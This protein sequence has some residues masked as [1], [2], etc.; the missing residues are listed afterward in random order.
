VQKF[1]GRLPLSVDDFGLAHKVAEEFTSTRPTAKALNA[2]FKYGLFAAVDRFGKDMAIASTWNKYTRLAKT[3]KGQA[4]IAKEFSAAYGD[5]LPQ[6]LLELQQKKHTD[7][8]DSLVFGKLSDVQPIS[9]LEMPQA[10]LEMP[11]G[12]VLYMLKSFMLKQVDIVRRDVYN[13]LAKGTAEGVRTGLGNATKYAL[14]LG[15]GGMATD[16]VKDFLL[17]KP[18]NPKFADAFDNVMKTFGWSSYAVDKAASGH[19]V[20]AMLNTAIPPYKMWD[21]ILRRDPRA[22]QYIPVVGKLIYAHFM[23]GKELAVDAERRRAAIKAKEAA[24]DDA[25]RALAKQ[26]KNEA[27]ERRIEAGRM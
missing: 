17:G 11:N 22:V 1:S 20:E 18:F 2:A 21:D 5:E 4:E 25:D 8:T 6:L 3:E 12:R 15:A 16:M 9:K 23:G 19:P 26:K 14:A 10:Y 13:E 27:R 24:M 7:L